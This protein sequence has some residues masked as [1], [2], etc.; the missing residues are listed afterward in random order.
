MTRALAIH[1]TKNT[2]KPDASGAFIPCAVSFQKHYACYREGFDNKLAP[3]KRREAVQAILRKYSDLELVAFFGHGLR[4][5]LQSGHDL[6]NVKA[7]AEAIAAATGPRVVVVLFACSTAGQLTVKRGG[8]A[9]ALRDELAR[10]GK[11]GHVDAHTTPGHAVSNPYVQRFDIAPHEIEEI[12]G[13]WLVPRTEP[14]WSR[15]RTR[16]KAT[17][18]RHRFPTMSAADVHAELR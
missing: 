15:W 2:T 8:F 16:L 4:R 17:D 10:L 14:L 12:A 13:D 18:I 3:P 1:A 7:L 5:S 9:D 6:T 11:T